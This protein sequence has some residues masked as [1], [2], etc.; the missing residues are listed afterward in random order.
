MIKVIDDDLEDIDNEYFN[1]RQ[2]FLNLCR[3]NHYQFD[4]LRRS[5]HTSMMVLWHLHNRGAPKFV[6]Q[7]GA[8]NREI[9]TGV[10]YHC[11]ICTPDFDL[12]SECYS[13]PKTDR[14]Q[15]NH[16]LEPIPVYGGNNQNE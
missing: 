14:G 4:E 13:N 11:K 6:Q 12:C 16:K 1:N 15:C 10:R 8:C 2:S 7:C 5:K 3:G 9:L